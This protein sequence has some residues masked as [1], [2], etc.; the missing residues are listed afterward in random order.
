M[1]IYKFNIHDLT[2]EDFYLYKSRMSE[3]KRL[4]LDKLKFADDKKR[5]VCGFMLAVKALSEMSNVPESDIVISYDKNSKPYSESVP[6]FFSIAHSGDFAVCAVSEES[7]GVDIEKIRPLNMQ[8]ARRF[9]N[10]EELQYIFGCIPTKSDYESADRGTLERFFE[11][12]TKK[13]A[14]GKMLGVGMGY[15]MRNTKIENA[16]TTVEDGYALTVC[17]CEIQKD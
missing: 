11:V 15:D 5:S 2:D 9:A 12:W 7:I 4:R 13:E 8:S 3:E 16:V 17:T 6:L 14:Y 10:E 1:K